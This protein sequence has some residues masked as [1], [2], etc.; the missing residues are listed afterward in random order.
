MQS[1]N[2]KISG[3]FTYPNRLGKD[4]PEGAL[5]RAKNIVIDADSIAQSRRGYD[6]LTGAFADVADRASGYF[7]YQSKVIARYTGDKLAY[8]NGSAWINYTGTYANPSASTKTKAASANDN[9]YLTSSTGIRKLDAYTNAAATAAGMYKGLDIT[10]TL[11]GTSGFLDF[12]NQVA[13]RHVWGIKDVNK[14]LI[15]GA[16][17]GQAVVIN[18]TATAATRDVSLTITIPTGITTAHFLQVYRSAQSGGALV[19]PND[20]LGLVYE[21][22]PSTGGTTTATTTNTSTTLSVVASVT[23]ARIGVAISGTGIPASTTIVS[24]TAST[25]VLSQAATATAAGITITIASELTAKSM[26]FIDQTPSNLRGATLY[27][28]PSQEGS[29]QSNEAPPSAKDIAAFNSSMFYA[30][31]ISKHRLNLAIL[32]VGG[33][34][35]V[36]VDDTV[37]IAGIVYT[38]KA[39][40]AV[41]SG[42]FALVTAGSPSQNIADTVNSLVRVI[43]QYASNTL[44]Y[45]SYTSGPDDLPGQFLI[46]E[47]SFGGAAFSAIASARGSAYSPALPTSGTTIAST[48]D[49]FL[50]AVMFS[51]VQQPEAV[52]LINVFRVGS[53]SKA[54]LRIVPLRDS[55]FVLKEDGIWR[56]LGENASN[57]RVESVDTSTKLLSPESAV[58]LNNQIYCLSDQGVV[59]VTETGVSVV[60]R[61]IEGDLLALFGK[62]KAGVTARSFGISYE[63]DRKYVLF[64]I[65]ESDDTTATQAYVYNVF[66]TAWT[67]WDLDKTCGFINPTDDKLYLGDSDS[68]YTNTERK[69]FDHTDYADQEADLTLVSF[70]GTTLTLND[71]STLVVGDMLYQSTTVNSV[72]TAIDAVTVSVTVRDTLT[73]WTAGTISLYAGIPFELE[74]MPSTGGNPGIIKNFQEASIFLQDKGFTSV[75]LG[76][77]TDMSAA[78]EEVV[79]SGNGVGSWGLF[80]WGSEAWG[81]EILQG[82]IRTY[83]PLEKSRGSEL[84]VRMSAR[85]A[86]QKFALQGISIPYENGNYWVAS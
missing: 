5:L 4:M 46:E 11:S 6:R 35:G 84:T 56:I 58:S 13:Y 31:T 81:G 39:T 77:K 61:P 67:R 47:R 40:E 83:V 24:F 33:A 74:W 66:T 29:V 23:Q 80:A 71:V 85:L 48:N 45:A 36:A 16:P 57:F 60:S 41:A 15:I 10:G 70:T 54:I 52:P 37:T 43:N 59:T 8:H 38:A 28:S 32:G 26:T 14:N 49:T 55:L 3:L 63:T 9:L 25:I 62:N 17:S 27:T 12:S 22:N 64:T 78:Y 86:Y 73:T 2:L 76:F 82:Q 75:S 51:K 19:T 50:N 53:A 65:T 68:A 69:S 34:S 30:N 42:Q 79:V 20:E 18:P 44:V 1:L 72:I 21:V 7:S